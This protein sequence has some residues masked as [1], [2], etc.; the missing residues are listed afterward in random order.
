MIDDTIKDKIIAI[1][2]Y[3]DTAT[4]LN[5]LIENI[6]IIRSRFPGLKIAL[7]ANYP[8]SDEIQKMVDKYFYED[9]NYTDDNKWIWYWN[10]MMNPEGT[11]SYFNKKFFYSIQD[12]GYSVF[13]QIRALTKYLI[14]YKWILLINY[15]TCVEEIRIEDYSSDYDL[16]VHH[17]PDQN[18][19]SLIM[20]SFNP[21]I[22]FDKVAKNFTFE[23]WHDPKRNDQ[24][25]EVRFYNMV[26]ESNINHFVHHYLVYDKIKNEPDYHQGSNAPVNDFFQKYL[27]YFVNNILEIYIW[28]I[29]IEIKTITMRIDDNIFVLVNQNEKGV[30]EHMLDYEYE[31]IDNIEIQKINGTNVSIE[32]KLKKG[33]IVRP[34]EE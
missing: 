21:R 15:D 27:L 20:M 26:L 25:N 12:S 5:V 10:I 13:Q 4:K 14:D 6:N 16:I 30:F 23:N 18:A 22:F 7:H 19:Y 8:L 24:L 11:F 2:S 31:K 1:T 9:L 17:F 3:C 33:Y 29:L 34:L 32:L 28:D